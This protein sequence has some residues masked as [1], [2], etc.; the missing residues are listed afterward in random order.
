MRMNVLE[1]RDPTPGVRAF[2]QLERLQQS[3]ESEEEDGRRE[4]DA[5][6]EME[7]SG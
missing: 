1:D 3:A 6:V 5:S 7:L 4:E 2:V